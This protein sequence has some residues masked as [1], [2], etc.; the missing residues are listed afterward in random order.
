MGTECGSN[1][2]GKSSGQNKR[3]EAAENS[4][5]ANTNQRLP[6]NSETGP[7]PQKT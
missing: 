7:S 1:K 5:G 6:W 3:K 2:M 4:H